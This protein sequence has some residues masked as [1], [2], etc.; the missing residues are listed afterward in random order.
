MG[1]LFS[2][3]LMSCNKCHRLCTAPHSQAPELHDHSRPVA[4][5]TLSCGHSHAAGKESTTLRAV[6]WLAKPKVPGLLWLTR[7]RQLHQLGLPVL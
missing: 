4:E 1:L 7:D 6:C 5:D 2:D 3:L